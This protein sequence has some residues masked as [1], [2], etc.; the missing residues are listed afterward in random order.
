MPEKKTRL[1]RML[2]A[3]QKELGWT[4]MAISS[5]LG[6]LQQTY[7]SWKRGGVPRTPPAGLAAF[8][9]VTDDALLTMMKEARESSE[10]T[11]IPVAARVYGRISDRKTGKFKFDTSRKALP[12]GRYAVVIDTKVM[13]PA[14]L[15]G[16]KAW[17][18]PSVSPKI[19]HEVLV[20][21]RGIAWLGRL[22]E[23]GETVRLDR[24]NA[25]PIEVR[26]VVA[27]HVVIASE[28]VAH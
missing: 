11:A 3:K 15:V 27:V 7:S 20:H 25:P 10:G 2:V 8:L 23:F 22:A 5:Q 26:D 19:G 4:D 9:G 6:V 13:E 1:A 21:Q 14:L 24:H 12:E 28:R 17:L 16:T 18:D